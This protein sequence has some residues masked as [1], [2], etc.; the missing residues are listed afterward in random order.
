M[1][2]ENWFK[3][4]CDR[5]LDRFRCS[6]LG[7]PNFPK[8]GHELEAWLVGRHYGLMS[9]YLDWTFSPFVA[10]FF[11][12]E[13]VYRLNSGLRTHYPLRYEGAVSVWSFTPWEP[14]VQTELEVVS[15]DTL[16]GTRA[17][18]QQSV[19]TR[20]HDRHHVDLEAYL[21][22]KQLGYYLVR[23]DIDMKSALAAVKDLKRMNIS[24]LTVF[25]DIH[26]A[27]LQANFYD[28]WTEL[29]DLLMDPTASH[30]N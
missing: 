20:L 2:G 26:G 11:A 19:F 7:L 18:S 9:P 12:F 23:Y 27:A 1:N 4:E 13:E 28:E 25:P 24:F 3:E 10:A 6:A 17:R 14:I 16:H 30:G 29:P 22:S 8:E 5:I 21:I 15:A